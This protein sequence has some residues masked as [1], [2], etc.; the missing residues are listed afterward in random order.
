VVAGWT[1]QYVVM[2]LKGFGGA[3]DPDTVAGF[4]GKL[5]G[6]SSLNLFWHMVFMSMTI[7]IVIGGVKGG[8]EKA[9]KILMPV[10]FVMLGVL[11]LRSISMPG[12][13]KALT[14]VFSPDAS[15]LTPG[16]VIEA[17]GQA[18]F[19]LSL[20][21]GAMLTYGSY[22]TKE[23]DLPKSAAIV[24][25]MDTGVALMASLIM[26]P[27]I[28][29]FGM[30]PQSGPG[31]V[32]KSLPIVFVQMPGGMFFAVVFFML[33]SFAAL[34]SAISLMEVVASFF[35]DTLKW[36]RIRAT[37]IPGLL[38]FVFGVPSAL[39]GADTSGLDLLPGKN[40][41]D[42]M[43]YIA[44]NWL[45]PLGGLCIAVFAVWIMPRSST[46]MLNACLFL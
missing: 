27:I 35:I 18:F 32:F 4:F 25:V 13:G 10:L 15:K 3:T 39:S 22:L 41:F 37:L 26:F 28:F 31:L 24:A 33:L 23:T 11:F 46:G 42:S 12:F 5:Y 36:D 20:G 21:M 38:I 16:A 44:S 43:D 1:L 9:S 45:L 14:F 8:I 29:S 17:M 7:G 19:S 30:S 2:A 6:S 40:V 34:T